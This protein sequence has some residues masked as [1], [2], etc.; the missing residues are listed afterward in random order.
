MAKINANHTFNLIISCSVSK[1][2]F[3][4]PRV[5]SN[6]FTTQK[7]SH[8]RKDTASKANTFKTLLNYEDT[9]KNHNTANNIND[10]SEGFLNLSHVHPAADL[11]INTNTVPRTSSPYRLSDL[12]PPSLL[13]VPDY[14]LTSPTNLP[15]SITLPSNSILASPLPTAINRDLP[16]SSKSDIEITEEILIGGR[17]IL[18]EKS[19]EEESVPNGR[20]KEPGEDMIKDLLNDPTPA[21]SPSSP[22]RM[23]GDTSLS[24][25]FAPSLARQIHE[26]REETENSIFSPPTVALAPLKQPI[27]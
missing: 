20:Q 11:H 1:L 25:L 14:T 3:S 13:N 27:C 9:N 18:N 22:I 12:T 5:T 26:I 24:S 16:S 21:L 23:Q 17:S 10:D 8:K 15:N 7:D 4:N 6:H 19:V 2:E